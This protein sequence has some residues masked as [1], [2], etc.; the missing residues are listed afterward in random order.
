MA[1]FD[2]RDVGGK[3]EAL[4]GSIRVAEQYFEAWNDHDPDAIIA[5]FHENG[6]YTDPVSGE[7]AGQALGRY[8]GVLFEAYPDLWFDI[9]GTLLAAGGKV[10][11]QW[12]MRGTNTGPLRGNPPSG[13]TIALPGA[14][15]IEVEGGKIRSV[16]GYF[17]QKTYVEQLGLQVILTP[18]AALDLAY[19]YSVRMSSGKRTRPAA[20]SVT[21]ID[22]DSDEAALQVRQVSRQITAGM[23]K[24]P[25]FI[26][27]VAGGVEN[28]LF[29]VT[30]WEDVES[31]RQ[32]LHSSRHREAVKDFF[33][34][35]LGTAVNTGVWVLDHSNPMWV[36]CGACG[37]IADYDKVAGTCQCGEPLP[38]APPY[39]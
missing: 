39:W 27:W 19:G 21:W 15:F 9:V 37:G 8:A 12:L 6:T 23:A 29:T 30:A 1:R 28:R 11:A 38:G 24:M 31:A 16:Q 26:T 17:D 10:S 5:L 22:T 14:D 36:Q 7:L 13:R 34:G 20:F 2:T 3:E 18:Q 33:A 4:I 25:G 32:L 35:S